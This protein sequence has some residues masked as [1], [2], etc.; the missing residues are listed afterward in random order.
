MINIENK[1]NC[2]G[3]YACYN[4]CSKNAIEM[5]E[6]EKGFKYPK[7]DKEKCINCGLCNN[8]CPIINNNDTKNDPEAYACYCK[9]EDIRK[10]S[11]S[12]GIFT[13]ITT[14]ILNDDGI[15][16]GAAFDKNFKVNHIR[17]EKIEELDKLRGSK[18]VQSDIG[19]TY[20]QAKKYLQDGKKVLFTGTPCQ[21]EGLYKYL[22][23]EYENLYTQDI[24]CHGVP[25]P[26][27]WEVYKKYRESKD[28]ND[29]KKIS[30]RNKDNGWKLYNLKFEYENGENYKKNQNEDLYMKVFLQDIS[31]RDS[32]YD[33]RFKKYNRISDITLADFWGINNILPEIDDN[34]GISLVII[35]SE[36]GKKIFEKINK[37]IVIRKVELNEAIKYNPSMTKSSNKNSNRENFF[38]DLENIN[39]E[40]LCKKY[41]RKNN[42]FRKVIRKMKKIIKI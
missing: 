19:D 28:N 40:K 25:S 38:K 24:I 32:C 5:I 14:E 12:G 34:K 26:K 42:Y 13:L 22:Q 23:K 6:N 39:F 3:C 1:T 8:V 9:D 29:I 41:L 15:V 31:L 11:S 20:K 7:I 17:I 16:F 30:F 18:Y 35:N 10:N 4:I 2:C 27:V 36:K 37:N 33:C 21:I